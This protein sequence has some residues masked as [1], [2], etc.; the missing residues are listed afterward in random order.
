LTEAAERD[1]LASQGCKELGMSIAFRRKTS[2]EE[3]IDLNARSERRIIFFIAILLVL[4]LLWP[5][6][7][8]WL[9]D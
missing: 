4:F 7:H 6:V 5:V 8:V 1:T 2:G 3:L 9:M